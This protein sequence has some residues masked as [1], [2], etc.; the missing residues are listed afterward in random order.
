MY[1]LSEIGSSHF[2]NPKKRRVG[3]IGKPLDIYDFKILNKNNR[4]CKDGEIG[5]LVVKG[6]GLFNGYY[7]NLKLTKKNFYKDYFKT[8]DI[9]FKDA[10]GYYYYVDR[11]KDL[12]IKGGVNIL[13]SE[14]DEAILKSDK[15]ILECATVGV[16]D[17]FYGEIIKSY[18]ILKKQNKFLI[19]KLKNT[20]IKKL[21]H[22]KSPD[23]IKLKK[24]FPKTASGK[25]I[26]RFIDDK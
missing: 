26:K 21:G 18:I 20:L 22:L 17:S 10:D 2:E 24:K 1:G 4:F 15:N 12:I 5:E 3:S 11:K 25:I 9:C 14:I 8:G 7:K 23:I 19:S 13:P 16:K 6:K